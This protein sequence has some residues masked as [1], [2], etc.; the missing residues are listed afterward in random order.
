MPA[1]ARYDFEVDQGRDMD[2]IVQDWKDGAGNFIVLT[3]ASITFAVNDTS[4]L[5]TPFATQADGNITI[6]NAT[7]LIRLQIDGPTRTINWPVGE[8]PYE[9]A[10][11][12]AAGDD[13][14]LFKG[15]ITVRQRL[16]G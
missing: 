10:V 2:L 1:A 9:F 4:D 15:F 13:I 5:T 11:H 14:A 16:A 12:L 7:H 3:G 8:C 6:D